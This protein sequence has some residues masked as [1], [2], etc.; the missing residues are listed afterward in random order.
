[1]TAGDVTRTLEKAL[2]TAGCSQVCVRHKPRLLS[3]NGPGYIA[4]DLAEWLE[5]QKIQHSGGRHVTLRP[6]MKL[7]SPF[8]LF[9]SPFFVM[10][11]LHPASGLAV[12]CKSD[13]EPGSV[14]ATGS[15]LAQR[16]PKAAWA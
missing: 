10:L 1:M 6:R 3:D 7:N 14:G 2:V 13:P 8:P 5:K 11:F 9:E 4:T 15:S 16:P 12:S